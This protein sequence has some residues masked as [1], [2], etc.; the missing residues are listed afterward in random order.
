ML[1]GQVQME[2]AGK[3]PIPSHVL[4][5][6]SKKNIYVHERHELVFFLDIIHMRTLTTNQ[7]TNHIHEHEV[8]RYRNWNKERVLAPYRTWVLLPELFP[9]TRFDY[10]PW[11]L[12]YRAVL[13]TG[14]Y[15]AIDLPLTSTYL[16][17]S[18]AIC[19]TYF[20]NQL[21]FLFALSS[22]V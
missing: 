12:F 2:G 10:L 15:L 9:P 8:H 21:C 7:P 18:N 19:Q 20:A 13:P 3:H 16:S 4:V 6:F 1:V 5:F 17:K 22:Y 11:V 14:N